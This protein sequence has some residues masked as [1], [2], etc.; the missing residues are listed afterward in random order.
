M[1]FRFEALR[2]AGGMALAV[3]MPGDPSMKDRRAKASVSEAGAGNRRPDPSG[4]GERVLD[5]FR[6][7][8]QAMDSIDGIARFWLHEDRHAVEACLVE[9]CASGQLEKRTIAGTDFYSLHQNGASLDGTQRSPRSAHPPASAMSAVSGPRAEA[10]PSGGGRLLVVDDDAS[11]REFMVHALTEAGHAVT[12]AEDGESALEIIREQSFDLVVTDVKMPGLSGLQVLEQIKRQSP[13]TEVIVV[14]AFATLDTAV[15]ALRSGAYDLITKPL[16]DIELLFRV[17]G[18]ALEKRRLSVENRM[19]VDSLQS[20]NL[21]LKETVARLAAVN[22]IG[23]ATTGVL[24]LDALYDALVRLVAQHLKARRVSVLVSEP[25]SDTMALVASVGITEDEALARQVR[26]G[27][28]ISG[29]VAASQKPL[30]VEDIDKSPLRRMSV[31]G[32]Y[33]T[34]S[35]MVSPLMVSYPIRY[36]RRRVGV[37][38]VS[39]KHSGDPFTEQ[40]LEF[41]ST[42]ASQVAAAIEN[43]RLVKEMEDGYF[44]VVASMIQSS[45]EAQKETRDHSARVATLAADV[46]RSLGLPEARVELLVRAAALHEVG[47]LAS[48]PEKGSEAADKESRSWNPAAVMATERVLAPIVSLREV[49]EILLRSADW[50]DAARRV[51][52]SEATATPIESQIFSACEEFVRLTPGNGQDP[53]AGRAA[54]ERL[55]K[56]SGR[57]FDPAVVEALCRLVSTAPRRRGGRS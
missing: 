51:P 52:G 40:D 21:E 15:K 36:Q 11:V 53:E 27:E 29:Q 43:A 25:G 56:L 13:A 38:N 34:P 44:N 39:D 3:P 22:E 9:L 49:R 37:I 33:A 10:A 20:R 47:R 41:L 55:E 42:L 57:R 16:E 5:Y 32:R 45:E 1:D 19:L 30:L 24:Q 35:F 46:A 23:R 4:I 26:V 48:R 12:S 2:L 6:R 18:R 54:V 7:N 31:G 28:G 50:F 17:A 14:T 8:A